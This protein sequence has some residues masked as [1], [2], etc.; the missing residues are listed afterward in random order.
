MSTIPISKNNNVELAT[1]FCLNM[2]FLKIDLRTELV[3]DISLTEYPLHYPLPHYGNALNYF[4]IAFF[5]FYL[6]PQLLLTFSSNSVCFILCGYLLLILFLLN[7]SEV[8]IYLQVKNQKLYYI[9]ILRFYM[10]EID[11][12]NLH[13]DMK[14]LIVCRSSKQYLIERSYFNF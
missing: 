1:S 14:V 3:C 13:I 4:V 2:L 8:L 12:E 6:K 7:F 5:P 10:K 11:L 9:K